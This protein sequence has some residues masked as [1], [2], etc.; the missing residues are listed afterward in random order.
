MVAGL[1]K[2]A[3]PMWRRGAAL[4]AVLRMA[5]AYR[6][7][8]WTAS[9][10]PQLRLANWGAML[11]EAPLALLVVL[12]PGSPLRWLLLAGAIAFHVGII[13]TMRFPFANLA[14]LGAMVV[15][16]GPE[17][18]AAL[19]APPIQPQPMPLSVTDVVA[20]ATTACLA[21]LFLVNAL[22]FDAGR[23]TTLWRTPS[24]PRRAFNPLYVPLWIIGLAQSYRLFDWID[25]RN[26]R[27]DYEICEGGRITPADDLFP[28]SM[29]HILLQSYL[30]GNLWLRL[31][32]ARLPELRAGILT[33]YA[34]RYL[35]R[36]PEATD[37]EVT[38]T[39]SRLTPDNLDL[40]R[41][42]RTRLMRF[43]RDGD[44]PRMLEWS[45]EP[46]AYT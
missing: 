38:A 6:P 39:V 21:L 40:H 27:V 24:S 34:R 12:P 25:Q 1:W 31:D 17:L 13:A 32:P 41:S 5:V 44:E 37:V 10:A 4:H 26:Y 43:R 11:I 45:L 7:D 14:M 23:A 36:H 30:H 16:F 18:M 9:L 29:R 2:L 8:T 22:W 35:A 46:P 33:R 19:G 42:T 28:V 15:F 20:V 3:S